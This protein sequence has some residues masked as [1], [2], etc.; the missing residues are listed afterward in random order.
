MARLMQLGREEPGW[1]GMG[2][3]KGEGK[4]M[5]WE[6]GGGGAGPDGTGWDGRPRTCV[7][8]VGEHAPDTCLAPYRG[9]SFPSRWIPSHRTELKSESFTAQWPA[10]CGEGR[11]RTYFGFK[12]RWVMP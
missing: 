3:G 4:G 6:G 8:T 12:F 1:D 11:S 10:L 7:T 9:S 2:W 5:G